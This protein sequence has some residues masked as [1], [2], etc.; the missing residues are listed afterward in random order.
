MEAPHANWSVVRPRMGWILHPEQIKAIRIT[1]SD[2]QDDQEL[3]TGTY[4]EQDVNS[5]LKPLAAGSQH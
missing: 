2:L 5:A 1:S 3:L 4:E